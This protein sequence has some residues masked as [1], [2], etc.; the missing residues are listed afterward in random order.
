MP[1]LLNAEK[2]SKT[3]I[4]VTEF[5]KAQGVEREPQTLDEDGFSLTEFL[6]DLRRSWYLSRNETETERN[7]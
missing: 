2:G 1:C 4:A 7:G 3:M 5:W 6:L